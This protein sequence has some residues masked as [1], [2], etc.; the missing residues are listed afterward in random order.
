MNED[1]DLEIRE[2]ERRKWKLIKL[3]SLRKEVCDLEKGELSCQATVRIVATETCEKFQITIDRITTRRRTDEVA[4][5]RQVIFY[6]AR[7]LCDVSSTELGRLF[8]R[9]H[10]TVLH[11]V[12]QVKNR[13]DVDGLFAEKVKSI[14]AAVQKRMAE[15]TAT[16]TN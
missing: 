14:M 8:K 9:D 16:A 1:I 2:L 12:A 6:V 10:G 3:A 5:P 15:E 4:V 13:M 11:G 7:E